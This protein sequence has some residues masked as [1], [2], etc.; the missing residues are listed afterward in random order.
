MKKN[1]KRLFSVILA[2][3]VLM[4]QV[5]VFA[6]SAD[7]ELQTDGIEIAYDRLSGEVKISGV[8]PSGVNPDEPVRLLI[9]KP[10]TDISDLLSGK[11]DFTKVGIHVAEA[12]LLED[13]SFLFDT[14][15]FPE[16]VPY[17]DYLV[18]VAAGDKL[19]DG[20][21]SIATK[22]DTF[23]ILSKAETAEDVAESLEK[24]NDIFGLDLT[25]KGYYAA[26]GKEGQA[27]V[28]KKMCDE[29]FES[30][31]EV[32]KAFDTY[33]QLY[34][35]YDGSWG[36]VQSIIETQNS[37]LEIDL[38]EYNKAGDRKTD[39]CKALCGK[40]YDSKEAFVEDFNK[41]VSE[42]TE[43]KPSSNRG[44]SSGGS[45]GGVSMQVGVTNNV[46]ET[47]KPETENQEPFKDLF[48]HGWAKDYIY[49]LYSKGVVNGKA[50]G[51]FAPDDAVTRAEA[52]K[53]I[54]LALSNVY[55]GASAE[56]SDVSKDSWMA[57]YVATAKEKG[58]VNGYSEEYFGA[59]DKITREDLAVIIVRAAESEGKTFETA[60]TKFS[61]DSQISDYA[62]DA[63][64]KLKSK[65]IISGM[66]DNEFMAKGVATRAQVAK[67]IAMLM[68]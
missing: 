31:T 62:K 26:I 55:D 39:I 43:E 12:D 11:T 57:P 27:F 60:K 58:F 8:A 47:Q 49:K 37:L 25:E 41:I 24:Y 19:Y 6:E 44:S 28:N 32:K 59:F 18:K 20:I 56:F 4:V 21:L 3:L 10:E 52:V 61:D 36:T 46:N 1:L 48:T 14:V 9:L 35:I 42:K 68:E 50:D 30:E 16:T 45:S 2:L 34:R 64:Y 40:L 51:I 13:N 38:T 29:D 33:T 15:T 53:M 54:V 65:N 66:G 17:G 67:M 63:V 5:S 22:A 23:E 7:K